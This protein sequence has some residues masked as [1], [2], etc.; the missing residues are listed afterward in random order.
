MK[1]SIIVA[2]YQ[3]ADYIKQCV[4]SIKAQ[5]GDWECI[6]RTETSPDHSEEIAEREVGDDPRFTVLE[7]TPSGGPEATRNIGVEMAKGDY[8]IFLD[9][10]DAL[11]PDSLVKLEPFLAERPDI[12]TIAID[13]EGRI[14][15][16][17]DM[18]D[19]VTNGQ[20]AIIRQAAAEAFPLAMTQQFVVRTDYIRKC[21]IK[22]VTGLNHQDEEVAPRLVYPAET[23]MA[24]HLPLYLYRLR[25]NSMTSISKARAVVDIASVMKS[26]FRY[27]HE[28]APAEAVSRAWA[29][30]W[31]TAFFY[32]FFHPRYSIATPAAKTRE[33]LRS[34]FTDGTDDFYFLLRFT[35]IP[36]RAGAM[37]IRFS[38][39]TGMI[40]PTKLFFRLFYCLNQ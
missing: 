20:D 37:M 24:T 16:P 29:R 19:G 8:L 31:F 9:G 7:G 6:F 38:A 40:W 30:I 25:E 33:A 18:I 12:A 10:D 13:W 32:C 39:V 5:K 26:H 2:C 1:F 34:L 21:G 17:W 15:D 35:S 11:A 36:K 4:E 28:L 22:F 14:R 27:N 3:S 23:I